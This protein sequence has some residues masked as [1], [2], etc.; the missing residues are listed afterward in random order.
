MPW[1][2]SVGDIMS[3]VQRCY[4]GWSVV[5]LEYYFRR[6]RLGCCVVVGSFVLDIVVDNLVGPFLVF[7]VGWHDSW[8]EETL[9][10]GSRGEGSL[11]LKNVLG[12]VVVA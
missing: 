6:L 3:G 10:V 9:V 8:E 2:L 1:L 7:G 11:V 12:N 4:P 5:L